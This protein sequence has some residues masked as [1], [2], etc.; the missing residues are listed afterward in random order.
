MHD[1]AE[2][3]P[4]AANIINVGIDRGLHFGAQLY[5]S[6][7]GETLVDT[8]F[9][10]A[11]I[12]AFSGADQAMTTEHLVLWLSASKP[13]GAAAIA[14]LWE[15]GKVDLD[16]PIAETIPEFGVLGKDAISLRHVLMHTGGFRDADIGFVEQD[17]DAAVRKVCDTPLEEG[18]LVGRSAGYDPRGAWYILGEIVRRVDGRPY[19]QYVRQAIFDPVGMYDSWIGMSSDAYRDYGSR[20]AP[21]YV[22]GEDGLALADMHSEANCVASFPAGNG[23]GPIRELGYFYEMLLDGGK[24]AGVRV[25]DSATT[26][27]FTSPHRVGTFDQTFKHKMD[28]GLGFILDSNRYGPQTVPYGYGLHSSKHTFG[29]GGRECVGAFAD[30]E[31]G[32]V[33]AV[34]FNGM[35]GEPRHNKRIRDFATALY[36]DLGLAG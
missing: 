33:V 9:G 36:E 20:I 34:M 5:V 21:T 14:Q 4:T 35:P 8:A 24:R 25:L 13:I 10:L 16:A 31:H 32:L 18:W 28:W 17:W 2:L 6:R 1:A 11:E 12:E 3:L 22:K 29:H 27:E 7:K 30:P 15:Q 19:H 23:R 26:E